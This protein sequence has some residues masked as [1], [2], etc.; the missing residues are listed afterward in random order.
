MVVVTSMLLCPAMF[1][2]LTRFHMLSPG[3]RIDEVTDLYICRF[4]NAFAVLTLS[5]PDE[6]AST[7]RERSVT[8]WLP[9]APSAPT[10][11]SGEI[12]DPLVLEPECAGPAE[13]LRRS[14]SVPTT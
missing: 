4:M 1:R 12:L 14:P 6:G 3:N 2:S 7:V 10:T 9:P 13:S 8:I 5:T 11:L